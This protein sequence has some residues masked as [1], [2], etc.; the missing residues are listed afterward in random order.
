MS[1][2]RISV[3]ALNGDRF[4]AYLSLPETGAGP[5]IVLVQEI[6]GLTQAILDATDMFARQGYVVLAPD[7]HWRHVRGFVAD[8]YSDEDRAKAHHLRDITDYG[9]CMEDVSAAADFLKGMDQCNGRIGVTGFCMG[10]NC[11]F[12]AAA[13]LEIDAAAGYYGTHIHTYLDEAEAIKRPL[14]LH[15]ADHDHTCT[16]EDRTRVRAALADHDQ[17]TIHDYDTGHAFAN[18][19]RPDVY[20]EGEACL[21]NQRSFALFDSLK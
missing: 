2:E 13:R 20:V 19:L 4:D 16:D 1:G 3:A 15:I 5:G 11:A 21:A 6:F 12:L 17:V 7:M 8:Y 14:I 18:T 9:H 10:G